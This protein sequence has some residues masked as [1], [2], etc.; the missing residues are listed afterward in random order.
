MSVV[1]M[2]ML[3]WMIVNTRK[4]RIQNEKNRLKVEVA[5]I[6]EKMRESRL[7]GLVMCRGEQL[8]HQ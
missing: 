6:D 1:E 3:K 8:M 7:D 4:D 2:R 5:P